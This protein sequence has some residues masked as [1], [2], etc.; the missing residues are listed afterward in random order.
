MTEINDDATATLLARSRDLAESQA[1]PRLASREKMDFNALSAS[2]SADVAIPDAEPA[3]GT[4]SAGE[5][6]VPAAPAS[7]A[8][9]GAAFRQT[10]LAVTAGLVVLLLVVWIAQRRAAAR[11]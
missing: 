11:R 4:L 5:V 10:R 9:D 8:D 1:Q 6:Q 2:L 7:V 3:P